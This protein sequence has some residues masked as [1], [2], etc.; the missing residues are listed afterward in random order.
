MAWLPWP[1]AQQ[2]NACW[3]GQKSLFKYSSC[4][5]SPVSSRLYDLRFQNILLDNW[6]ADYWP[7]FYEENSECGYNRQSHL[8]IFFFERLWI[9]IL[10]DFP[11]YFLPFLS[12]FLFISAWIR[13]LTPVVH[14]GQLCQPVFLWSCLWHVD[15]YSRVWERYRWK[16]DGFQ[17]LESFNR[18]NVWRP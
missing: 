18:V 9:I 2:L 5:S 17:G 1:K 8:E 12:N 14:K 13:F 4:Y 10:V 7:L 15:Y 16:G 11:A 6:N 3:S